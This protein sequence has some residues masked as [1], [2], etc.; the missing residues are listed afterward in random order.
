MGSQANLDLFREL[1]YLKDL[2]A[3]LAQDRTLAPLLQDGTPDAF[4]IAIS[5]LEVYANHAT[6]HS[7]CYLWS[8]TS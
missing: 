3:F 8:H 1:L 5:S 4:H 2:P 7:L 6:P